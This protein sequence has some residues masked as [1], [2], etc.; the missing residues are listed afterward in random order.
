MALVHQRGWDAGIFETSPWFAVLADVSC[1]FLAHDTF[2]KLEELNA[3]LSQRY[4]H[5]GLP[6]LQAIYSPPKTTHRKKRKA[7]IEP[8]SLYDVRI[9]EHGE[10]PTRTD[11]WHDFFN[12]LAFAA[13]P[14]SKLALHRRQ[15]RLLRARI[16]PDARRLP[17]ARTREQDALT[18]LDE[19][20]VI[21]ACAPEAYARLLP[22]TDDL[23]ATLVPCLA[24]GSAQLVPFGH[25]LF[26][27]MVEGLHCPL[28]IP[29]L[30][31]LE[32]GPL[33]DH[34]CLARLDRALSEQLQDPAKF[35]KP[36][37]LKGLRLDQ[38]AAPFARGQKLVPC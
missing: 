29:Q 7:P 35:L 12:V 23:H 9:A 36:S 5:A 13:W 33:L 6:S 34:G 16:A 27:H 3:L 26:E 10:L 18:L 4:A 17:G 38:Y 31:M 22:C 15:S 20:G 14:R 32:D 37:G 8:S 2:P 11:D 30:V 28:S 21:V 19:G 25:A 24:A 1:D